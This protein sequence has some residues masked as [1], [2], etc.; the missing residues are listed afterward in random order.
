M[1]T[2]QKY[3]YRQVTLKR[4]N[5]NSKWILDDKLTRRIARMIRI[6]Q[7]KPTDQKIYKMT[8]TKKKPT[9]VALAAEA[10]TEALK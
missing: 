8:L 4:C 7:N 9:R 3:L 10:A 6:L 5:Q 2:L 1:L